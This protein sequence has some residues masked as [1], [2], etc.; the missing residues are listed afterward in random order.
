VAAFLERHADSIQGVLGCF[1]R[2]LIQGMLRYLG[3]SYEITKYFRVRKMKFKQFEEWATPYSERI[4]ADVQAVAA[5]A[6]IE[7]QP[8][9]KPGSV[10]KEDL[11]EAVLE[12]R[13]RH[14][15]VVHI[16]SAM[17]RCTTYQ[18]WH[19]KKTHENYLKPRSGKCTHFYIYYIDEELNLCHLRIPTWA[20]FNL[21]FCMNGHG[22][23]ANELADAGIEFTQADNAF[24]WVEDMDAAQAIADGFDP[25]R[26]HARLEEAVKRF[27][28]TLLTI[29]GGIQWGIA[30]IEYSTDIVFGRADVLKPVYEEIVRTL[31]HAVKPD[32]ISM[33]LGKRLAPSFEG[34]M[35]TGFVRRI[36]GICLRHFMGPS[37]IKIYDKYG[38][39]LRIECFTNKVGSFTHYRT[40]DHRDGSHS[41]TKAPVCKTIY[42]LPDLRDIMASCNRRYLEFI[43]AVDDPSGAIRAVEKISRRVRQDDRTYPGFNVFMEE[44]AAVLRAVSQA[45]HVSFGFRNR[46]LRELLPRKSRGQIGRVIKRLRMHGLVKKVARSFKY[47][48]T[49]LGKRVAATALKLKEMFVIPSLRGHLTTT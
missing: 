15:G 21:Q 18:A 36:E 14:P 12:T 8:L 23:L 31:A 40:V 39:I 4:R 37:G 24:T 34:E 29:D 28:P 26:L 20:P 27:V 11:V 41:F 33:F 3:N 44:D 46:T 48:L 47:Y 32:Q 13:G 25:R 38:R 49:A 9:G 6:G 43:G 19:D 35:G 16:I 45:Q 42:S 30:Q 1:D 22:W 17:E 7:I 10:R 5:A 2:I